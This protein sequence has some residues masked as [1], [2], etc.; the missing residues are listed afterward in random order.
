MATKRGVIYLFF[1]PE[2]IV[3]EFV[4]YKFEQLRPFVDHILVMSNCPLKETEKAKL[5]R[6][7]DEVVVRPNEGFDVGGYIDGLTHLGWDKV[8]EFDELIFMNYT[9]F[10]PL[11]PFSELFART[12]ALDVDFWGLTDHSEVKP[13]PIAGRLILPR[14]IQSHWIAVRNRLLRSEAFRRYWDDMPEITS[15]DESVLLHESRFTQHFA[16]RG[17]R[18]EVL[19]P[20]HAYASENAVLEDAPQ[21]VRDGCTIV[22][23]RTFFNDPLYMDRHALLGRKLMEAIRESSDYPV[24][25][26]WKNLTRTCKPRDLVMNLELTEVLPDEP[27]A[28]AVEAAKQ[29]RVAAL[30]HVFYPEML[31]EILDQ[32]ELLPDGWELFIT[33]PTEEK[34][35]E[36]KQRLS[37]RGHSAYVRKIESNRGR[38]ISAFLLGC[39]DVLTS[40]EFDLV[41][42][43]HSKLSPQD[44]PN[45]GGL[46][47]AHLFDNLLGTRGHA[48]NVLQLFV[49]HPNL[50]IVIPPMPHIG[51]PTMGHA[52]FENR[53]PARKLMK[54]MGLSVPFD[55]TTPIA[56]YG[57]MF[58]ARPELLRPLIDLKLDWEDFPGE[59]EYS[60]G[61]LAH[62]IERLF[63]YVCLAQGHHVRQVLNPWHAGVNYSNLEYK[64]Q[65]V[66]SYLPARTNEAVNL[67]KIKR[68]LLRYDWFK[69]KHPRLTKVLKPVVKQARISVFR[70]RSYYVR[71]QRSRG[72]GSSRKDS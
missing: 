35:A 30:A 39:Q 61:S 58:I 47:K 59:G 18:Y 9:F 10:G 38:D 54:K 25:L 5:E 53:E 40:G 43:I 27:L 32:V 56:S 1:D 34:V 2:G 16:A 3:D 24:E 72:G 26:I 17:Y 48:A 42:K 29:L 7:V 36:I 60:D 4:T 55:A 21:M 8:V 62:V 33:T 14:H 15:Y 28:G 13:H 50:G 63:V 52:W 20:S 46:F 64:L 71:Y 6:V 65:A 66:H 51:Y 31:D 12:E 49:D 70:A 68:F 41:L 11:Q 69:D 45:V 23:R 44:G 22:K 19:W 37:A 57:S 67:L